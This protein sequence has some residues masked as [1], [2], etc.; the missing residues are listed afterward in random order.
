M[1]KRKGTCTYILL[2]FICIISC[3]SNISPKVNEEKEPFK[4]IIR[5]WPHHHTDTV[6]CNELVNSLTTYKKACDEVWFCTELGMYPLEVHRRSA[7]AMAVAMEKMENIGVKSSIQIGVSIGHGD[8]VPGDFSGIKWGTVVGRDGTVSHQCN[9]PRQPDFLNYM[10]ELAEIYGTCKPATLWI[11][12]DLRVALHL[13]IQEL[14]YCPTCIGLFNQQ[15]NTKWTRETLVKALDRNEN[16]GDLRGKWIA[17]GQESL[18][19]VARSIAKGVHRVSPDTQMGLQHYNGHRELLNGYDWNPIFDAM[20]EE[21]G[22]A[23]ASRPGNGFYNDHA[24]REMIVKGYDMARQIRRLPGYVDEIAAEVE[25]YQHWATGKSSHGLTVESFL[26]LA[27]G[28]NQLSYAILCSAFEPMEWYAS[29]YLK[30]LAFW[31]S[32]YEEYVHYNKGTQPG[33]INPY[34]SKDYA[35]CSI[36]EENEEWKWTGCNAGNMIFLLAPLGLPFCPDGECPTALIL[37]AAAIEGMPELELVSFLRK[38]GLLLGDGTLDI[39]ERRNLLSLLKPVSIPENLAQPGVR[40]FETECK[41]RVA[42]ISFNS[43][44]SNSQ[45]LSLLYTADWIS[46]GKLPVIVQSMAQMQVIP[47]VNKEGRLRSI[48]FINVSISRQNKMVV[49]LRG[50]PLVNCK[51]TWMTPENRPVRLTGKYE[52]SDVVVTI[53]SIEGWNVGWLRIE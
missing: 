18:A 46:N 53:P 40:F 3:Q 38:G 32:F 24:P 42:Y 52:D 1:D 50:C 45:R 15:N 27:M 43:N 34:I 33:G 5:L 19:G 17:F 8:G 23:P 11:D 39:L 36:G 28:C 13:P 30:D 9:C 26:Y 21:T 37:D 14:C 4:I 16:N 49:R 44:I 20:K 10:G 41:G 51:L 35:L 2:L 31:R 12:D 7:K 22:R 48:A 6:L 47:R 25:G 29:N